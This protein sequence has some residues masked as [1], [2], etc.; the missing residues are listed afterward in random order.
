MIAGFFILRGS[1]LMT[2]L[3]NVVAP[4]AEDPVPVLGLSIVESTVI[5][6]QCVLQSLI[7]MRVC[8]AHALLPRMATRLRGL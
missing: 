2:I 6:N 1:G 3:K 4:E 5:Q 8:V 7:A